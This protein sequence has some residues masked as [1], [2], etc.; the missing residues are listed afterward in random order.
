[1]ALPKHVH[2]DRS[3]SI[4]FASCPNMADG[5][6][7]NLSSPLAPMIET[8]RLRHLT[9]RKKVMALYAVSSVQLEAKKKIASDTRS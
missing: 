5:N 3:L 4:K 9:I 2:P 1:M 7:G 8:A 6:T